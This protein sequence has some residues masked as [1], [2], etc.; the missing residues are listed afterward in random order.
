MPLEKRNPIFPIFPTTL[1]STY[2]FFYKLEGD[3]ICLICKFI[4]L[5]NPFKYIEQTPRRSGLAL[6]CST[7][8]S[9][10]DVLMSLVKVKLDIFF[11]FREFEKMQKRKLQMSLFVGSPLGRK[12]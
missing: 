12:R 7:S 11:M 6:S 10:F 3:N 8:P 9:L 4:L 1:V 2:F 5:M